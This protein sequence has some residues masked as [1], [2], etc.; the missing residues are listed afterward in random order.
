MKKSAVQIDKMAVPALLLLLSIIVSTITIAF[1]GAT[2]RLDD[3]S[4]YTG[5]CGRIHGLNLPF[6]H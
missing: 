4:F 2:G 3:V 1:L 5:S 6:V